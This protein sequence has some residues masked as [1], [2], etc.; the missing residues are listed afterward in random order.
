MKHYNHK[1]FGDDSFCIYIHSERD[2]YVKLFVRFIS[3]LLLHCFRDHKHEDFSRIDTRRMNQRREIE[4]ERK[5]EREKERIFIRILWYER[6][7]ELKGR[8]NE[9]TNAENRASEWRGKFF[10]LHFSKFCFW[11]FFSLCF[12]FLYYFWSIQFICV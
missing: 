9:G 2:I 8:T 10:R 7:R 5:W 1:L 11:L 12:L 6:R 3:P 4:L